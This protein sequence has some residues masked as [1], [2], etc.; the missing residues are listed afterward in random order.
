MNAFRYH[1]VHPD[2]RI[3]I[4]DVPFY[5]PAQAD[6][7]KNFL[8]NRLSKLTGHNIAYYGISELHPMNYKLLYIGEV[9]S[10]LTD[11]LYGGE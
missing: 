6:G 7:T 1:L 8:L 5:E 10:K 9:D 3:S 11:I 2:G 4:I